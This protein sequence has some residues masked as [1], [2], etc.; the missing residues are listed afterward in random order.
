MIGFGF[1]C[2]TSSRNSF[3]GYN[4]PDKMGFL[5]GFTNIIGMVGMIIGPL[6]GAFIN[7]YFGFSMVFNFNSALLMCILVITIYYI[8]KDQPT[9]LKSDSSSYGNTI[10][11]NDLLL[12]FNC[13]TVVACTFLAVFCL[14]IKEAIL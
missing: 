4:Y 5:I 14:T 2:E 3:I 8:P 13:L 9:Y 7:M 6:I 10:K 11:V 12:R 1:G